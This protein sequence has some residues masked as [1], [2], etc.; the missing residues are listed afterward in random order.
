MAVSGRTSRLPPDGESAW[1]PVE[2]EVYSLEVVAY[3]LYRY[4][5]WVPLEDSDTEQGLAA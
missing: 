3:L 5:V 1:F 4:L 2:S